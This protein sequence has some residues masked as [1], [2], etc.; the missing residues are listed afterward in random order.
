MANKYESAPWIKNQRYGMTKSLPAQTSVIW[1]KALL[2]CANGDGKLTAGE[3]DWVLGHATTYHPELSAG[4]LDELRRYDG[5]GDT[6]DIEKLVFSDS[7]AKLG[8]HVL[9]YEAIQASAADGDYSEGERTTIR[10]MA[11]RLGISGAKVAELE[12]LHDEERAFRAKS[13]NVWHP[14]GIPGEG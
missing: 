11:G 7:L 10:K 12:A 8:R 3:R 5:T 4:Q 14:E 1:Y 6:D 13:I 9:V 2:L